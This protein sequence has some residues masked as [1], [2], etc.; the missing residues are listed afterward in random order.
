MPVADENVRVPDEIQS[1]RLAL[2]FFLLIRFASARAYDL[3]YDALLADRLAGTTAG[4][5]V[6]IWRCGDR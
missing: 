5:I 1:R 2:A 4:R 6:P 3:L